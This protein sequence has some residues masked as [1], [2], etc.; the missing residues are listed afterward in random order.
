MLEL[1]LTHVGHDRAA[2]R[3]DDPG[4]IPALLAQETTRVLLVSASQVAV[5]GPIRPA[6]LP[7]RQAAAAGRSTG[8]TGGASPDDGYHFLGEADHVAYLVRVLPAQDADLIGDLSWVTL[9]DLAEAEDAD[10]LAIGLAVE[11]VALANWHSASEHCPRCGKPTEVLQ[12][13]W[14]RH[15]P[16][17][18]VDHHPRT[19][20]AVIMTIVDADDRLLLGRGATWPPDRMSV[21]AGFVEPGESAEHAVVREAAEEA[22]VAVG[23]VEYR[24]SQ[25]WPMP[26]SLMLGFRARAETTDLTPDSDELVDARWFTRADLAA[27]YADGTLRVPH[28][29]SIARALIEEW[30]GGPLSPPARP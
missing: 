15:C 26:C 12:A 18:G 7:V 16:G 13:G 9:R 2:H 20:P 4:L 5:S 30:F 17:E 8:R 28:R 3:R 22:G 1:P 14:V 10:P 6:L 24:G 25:A 11:A 23:Q 29:A 27:A 19:D 21:L